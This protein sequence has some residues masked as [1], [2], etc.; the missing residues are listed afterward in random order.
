MLEVSTECIHCSC[1]LSTQL[2]KFMVMACLNC[3]Q[4]ISAMLRMQI[5]RVY[6]L[7]MSTSRKSLGHIVRYGKCYFVL[8]TLTNEM[9]K[10]EGNLLH[11]IIFSFAFTP[12]RSYLNTRINFFLILIEINNCQ[13]NECCDLNFSLHKPWASHKPL[14]VTLQRHYSCH[15]V[16]SVLNVL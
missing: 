13:E 7:I 16:G 9:L 15:V 12:Q 8:Y 5:W 11:L 4:S 6:G 2:S 10:T 3:C 14:C 1:A